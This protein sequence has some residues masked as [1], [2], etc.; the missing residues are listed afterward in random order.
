MARSFDTILEAVKVQFDPEVN[1]LDHKVSP[2]PFRED[3]YQLGGSGKIKIGYYDN[4]PTMPS[5]VAMKRTVKIAKEALESQGY[6]LV[7]FNISEQEILEYREIIVGILANG[8]MV[9]LADYIISKGEDLIPSYQRGMNYFRS[10]YLFKA[11]LLFLLGI[12]GN[13]RIQQFLKHFRPLNKLELEALVNKRE[14]LHELMR[15]KI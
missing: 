7:P 2:C 9:P 12:S 14:S 13:R 15:Q 8:T 4:M 11:L 1:L 5:T 3:L 10:S 6:E